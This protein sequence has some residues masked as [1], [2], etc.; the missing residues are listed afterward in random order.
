MEDYGL[1]SEIGRTKRVIENISYNIINQII[2]IIL[3]FVSRTVFIWGIGI[4]YLGINGLFSDILSLLSMA[5]LGFNTAMTYSFYKPLVKKDY[6][7]ITQLTNF[8][9][10]VYNIIAIVITVLGICLVPFLPKLI[11]LDYDI[12]NL[13]I[14]YLLSLLSVVVSYLCIYKTTILTADQRGFVITKITIIT[15]TLKTVFQIIS[16]LIWK[17]YIIY[18]MIGTLVAIINNL[19]AS[20]IAS[21]EY[22]FI[23][24]DSEPISKLEK[25]NIINNLKSVF[26]YKVSSV[27]LN[28]TDNILISILLGTVMVGYYSNYLLL[29]TKITT[30]I[31]LVFTSMT[32]S[33]GHLI[34]TEGKEKRYEIFQCQQSISFFICGIIIPCYVLLVDEFINLWLG[35]NYE[36]GFIV[37]CA[38]GLNMY[39]GCV[40]Q[41]LW[42]YREATGLYRRTKW[43]MV[44]CAVINLLLSA[45]LGKIFGIFG[46]I[47]ASG[48]ARVS[49]YVW[50]E[51]HILFREYFGVHEKV[52][53]SQLF[54]NMFLIIFMVLIGKVISDYF[55]I[56]SFFKWIQKAIVIGISAVVI[57]F[58]I[59]GRNKG[60]VIFKKKMRDILIDL[61]NSL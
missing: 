6:L 61:R 2:T 56:N 44:I 23:K 55:W 40:L 43:I 37:S 8:Y 1:K 12:P 45:I 30:I 39:L 4:G 34:V 20:H 50:Y 51:P 24:N 5:D 25:E 46:I 48:I 7:K 9:K 10:K 17:N 13:T 26:L 47:V 58:F 38:I 31:S 49:T 15:N 53:Y 18:L 3:S 16:I 33:I 41:P 14:Y 32:A 54:R 35:N 29:Q 59:Y 11:N 28:A 19:Y 36:L 57:A 22:P 42:S 21:K 60:I 27:L 52:Y